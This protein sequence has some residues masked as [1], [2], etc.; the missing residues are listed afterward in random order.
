MAER[1]EGGE[2][3]AAGGVV[4]RTGP[5]GGV[6]ILLIHRPAYD[7]W[8]LPKGK[9]EE[10]ETDEACAIREVEEE[11]ALR[12]RLG[13]ELPSVRWLDRFDRPKVARYWLAEPVDDRPARPR[14]EVDSVE[15]LAVPA[16]I[17]RLTYERDADLIRSAFSGDKTLS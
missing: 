10:D 2:V 11:T 15:W 12:C 6:E 7:D 9:V 14:N 4:C 17:E 13:P 16:A 5:L 1:N 3:R 8:T